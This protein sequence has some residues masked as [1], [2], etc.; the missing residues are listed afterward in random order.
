VGIGR[1]R[2]RTR[3]A[4][5]GLAM[6]THVVAAVLFAAVIAAI[7]CGERSEQQESISDV[8]FFETASRVRTAGNEEQIRGGRG[9]G[10]R[11]RTKQ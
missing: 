5:P 9:R 7:L 11:G 8:D 4:T 3:A 1:V 10:S 2:P 6:Q